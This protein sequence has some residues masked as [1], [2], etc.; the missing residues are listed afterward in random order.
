VLVGNLLRYVVGWKP[1]ARRTAVYA[2]DPAGRADLAAAHVA[3]RPY[4]AGKLSLDEVLVVGPG[5]A[6]VL[7][8]QAEVVAN[9][10][11]AGG[12]LLAIGLAED[13]LSAFLPFKVRMKKGEHIATFFEPPSMNSLL[14]GVGPAEVHNRDPREFPLVSAGAEVLGD[15]IIGKLKDANVVFCQIAPSQFDPLKQIN[16]KRTYRRASFLMSR[17]LGNMGVA[18]STPLL[19]RFQEPV[20]APERRWLNGLYLDQPEEWDDPYR[21]FRW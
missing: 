21:F 7:D 11:K 16:L 8:G 5:A 20:K 6:R 18:G 1:V 13:E 10:L 3:A 17:L 12:N 15:G 9:W 2:G 19:N 14:A 4:D